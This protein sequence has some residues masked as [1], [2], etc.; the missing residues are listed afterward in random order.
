MVEITPTPA[1]LASGRWE[2]EKLA[3]AKRAIE[4]DGF[5]VLKNVAD[6]AHIDHVAGRM[7]EDVEAFINRPDAPFNW[8]RGNLQQDPP[9][10]EPYLY[11]DILVNDLI[12]Q[13]THSILGDGLYNA[14]YSG[15][16]ALANSTGR[17]PV[18]ADMGHLWP[19]MDRATPAYA[20]VVNF[21]MVDMSAANG[22]TEIWPGTHLDTSCALQGDDIKIL[23]ERLEA[24]RKVRPPI[25]PTVARGSAVIRDMRM[26]HAGMPNPCD[27]HRPM[28]AMIH[29]VGWW[30]SH[31]NVRFSAR[32]KELLEHP[33]LQTRAQWVEGKIDHTKHGH[34][35]ELEPAK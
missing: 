29:W 8:N 34:S 26:W 20:L 18:H 31:D 21:P 25:Q 3:A 28:I 17:Q 4:V 9:P 22:S 1:E 32:A 11:R 35:Y 13:V 12:I 19:N 5:V 23:P 14:F 16:T 30:P 7:L 10:F 33:V 6:V 27:G 2:P 15:N 24:Q